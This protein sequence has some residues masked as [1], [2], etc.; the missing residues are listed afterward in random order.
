MFAVVLCLGPTNMAP[1]WLQK[2]GFENNRLLDPVGGYSPER[3][4]IRTDKLPIRLVLLGGERQF[5][6]ALGILLVRSV[7]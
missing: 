3:A 2:I 6:I 7:C 4:L 5:C 1:I